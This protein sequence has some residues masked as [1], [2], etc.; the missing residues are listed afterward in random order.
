MLTYQVRSRNFVVEGKP[1]PTFPCDVV[2]RFHLE[3]IQPFGMQSGGGRTAVR[4]VPATTLMNANTGA[5]T[6]ESHFP[7]NSLEVVLQEHSETGELSRGIELKGNVLEISQRIS[8]LDKLDELI[9]SLYFWRA[10]L[11][12]LEFADPPVVSRVDG[13]IGGA[14]F[15]WEL[16]N[17]QM[18]FRTTTQEQQEAAVQRSWERIRTIGKDPYGRRIVA[19]IHYFYVACRLARQAGTPGEFLAEVLLNLAKTLEVLFPMSRNDAGTIESSRVSTLTMPSNGSA[20]PTLTSRVACWF[21][22]I[23]SFMTYRAS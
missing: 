22:L 21:D 17:W 19:A 15:R 13:T 5:H 7:L 20:R 2:I 23:H 8:A 3:P 16:A 14:A 18:Q 11:L 6:I 9:T 12:N 1:R 10:V 4:G